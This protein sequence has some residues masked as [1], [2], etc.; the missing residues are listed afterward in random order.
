MLRVRLNLASSG[1]TRKIR[2]RFGA[3]Y[4]FANRLHFSQHQ[5]GYLAHAVYEIL[6]RRFRFPG[7]V[8]ADYEI[9]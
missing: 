4:I 7:D 9:T 3:V 1:G 6:P 8:M 5:E 2:D